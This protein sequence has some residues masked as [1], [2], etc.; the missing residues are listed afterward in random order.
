M[1]RGAARW[2]GEVHETLETDGL[3]GQLQSWLD[4]DPLPDLPSFLTKMNRYT[5]LAAEARVAASLPPR[6]RDAWL[7]PV[8]EIFRRLIWKQGLWDGP[9]GWAFCLL[10]GLSEWVLADKHRHL[11]AARRNLVHR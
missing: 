7:A 1:R 9:E 11:W 6:R 8:R 4:H 2:T 5:T 3:V 10:S